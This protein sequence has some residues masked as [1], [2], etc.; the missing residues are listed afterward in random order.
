MS[1]I[2]A[3]RHTG[4]PGLVLAA[5]LA[6]LAARGQLGPRPQ[7]AVGIHVR[8]LSPRTAEAPWIEG[9]L[10]DLLAHG[11]DLELRH[12]V[13]DLV[14]TLASEIGY[15]DPDGDGPR[16]PADAPGTP[17]D[18]LRAFVLDGPPDGADDP[19]PVAAALAAWRARDPA[20]VGP[21]LDLLAELTAD[22]FAPPGS[23]EPDPP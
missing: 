2:T 21:V 19:A 3:A 5:A 10:L 7:S 1:S 13:R 14:R 15:T 17:A 4:D 23:A 6:G 18:A 20:R 11:H 8:R 16:W 9:A 22:V 12:P